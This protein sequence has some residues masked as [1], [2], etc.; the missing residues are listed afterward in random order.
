MPV[1]SQYSKCLLILNKVPRQNFRRRNIRR[2]TGR[3]RPEG[4]NVWRNKTSSRTKHPDGQ[5]VR[6][7]KRLWGQSIWRQN[8]L[9]TKH[10][11]GQK[12][13]RHN[14]RLGYILNAHSRQYLLKNILGVKKRIW[15]YDSM[16]PVHSWTAPSNSLQMTNSNRM[17]WSSVSTV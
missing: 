12:V 7:T 5:S 13:R 14:I 3:K 17:N 10:P 1:T 11:W 15:H 4:Q 16:I 8:I 9:G 6:Q 2:Q